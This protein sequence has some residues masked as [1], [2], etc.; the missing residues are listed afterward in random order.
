MTPAPLTGAAYARGKSKTDYGTP[1]DLMAAVVD[2]FGPISFDLAA[3]AGNHKADRWYGPGGE[4]EES[5]SQDWTKLTGN[6]WLNPPYDDIEPWARKCAAS[7]GF[8]WEKRR[9]LFLV[10]ASVGAIWFDEHVHGHALVLGL[11][12][13]LTFVNTGVRA[14]VSQLG[15]GLPEE[16]PPEADEECEDPYP[17]DLILAVYS[18]P[19]GFDTWRWR[20][21]VKPLQSNKPNVLEAESA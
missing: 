19:P 2:R 3:H 15:L 4:A 11:V 14:A 5:L 21:R 20:D 18:E 10:P 1:E 13:R 17:K 9:I 12:G 16:P 8:R 6:L 7:R